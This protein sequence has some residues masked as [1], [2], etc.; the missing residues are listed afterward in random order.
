MTLLS[1]AASI[2]ITC[3]AAYTI[4]ATTVDLV[5]YKEHGLTISSF[6]LPV[7]T[8]SQQVGCPVSTWQI[9]TTN[10]GLNVAVTTPGN[11]VAPA[12]I[13]G[14]H[15]VKP[16]NN[17]LH[18]AYVFYTRIIANGG[19]NFYF[20]P[21]D[22]QMGCFLGSVT[23]TDAPT[24]DVDKPMWVGDSV[25][26]AYTLVVPTSDRSWCTIVSHEIVNPDGTTWTPPTKIN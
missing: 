5:Q 24:F 6:V 17:A 4:A 23:Y 22:L 9:S 16:T 21:Y 26:S 10:N 2:T 8:S 13:S 18:Q 1:P 25:T 3:S 15:Q 12:I 19:S 14:D 11:L 20:G 7:Y